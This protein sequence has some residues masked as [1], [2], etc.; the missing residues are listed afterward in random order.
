M[1]LKHPESLDIWPS[2][3]GLIQGANTLTETVLNTNKLQDTA[4][5]LRL[6]MRD[7]PLGCILYMKYG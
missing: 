3:V 7:N 1:T 4:S 2:W 6:P 5:I